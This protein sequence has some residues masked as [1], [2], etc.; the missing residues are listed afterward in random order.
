[1]SSFGSE[2]QSDDRD[3]VCSSIN[4]TLSDAATTKDCYLW[5]AAPC[6][7]RPSVSLKV[8]PHTLVRMFDLY[9][10]AH[11]KS[12]QGQREAHILYRSY[13]ESLSHKNISCFPLC[14][15]SFV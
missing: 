8:T 4:F 11:I 12:D 10:C 2:P 5:T 1:M 15:S 13:C 7:S 6:S 3:R 14:V 9:I